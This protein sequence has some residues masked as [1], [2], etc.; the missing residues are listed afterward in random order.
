L[1][2]FGQVFASD[3]V[4]LLKVRQR[5]RDLEQSMGRSQRQR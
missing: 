4:S 5:A 3:P 1:Q 2:R